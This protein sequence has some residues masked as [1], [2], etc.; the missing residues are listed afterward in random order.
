MHSSGTKCRVA[1][2][3]TEFSDMSC[4]NC[5]VTSYAAINAEYNVELIIVLRIAVGLS[6]INKSHFSDILIYCSDRFLTTS[7]LISCMKGKQ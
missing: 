3:D 1:N 4:N 6:E 5:L 2:S 7:E